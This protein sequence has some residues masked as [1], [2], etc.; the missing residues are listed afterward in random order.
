MANSEVMQIKLAMR[1]TMMSDE[2]DM[3][4]AFAIRSSILDIMRQVTED[5]DQPDFRTKIAKIF[6]CDN[7]TLEEFEDFGGIEKVYFAEFIVQPLGYV[8]AESLL[9]PEELEALAESVDSGVETDTGFNMQARVVK[10][11]QLALTSVSLS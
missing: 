8:M 9:T 6:S 5:I 11:Q 7:T 1:L 4:A 2:C 10:R 3:K